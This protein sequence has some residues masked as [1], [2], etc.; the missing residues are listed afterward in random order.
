LIVH[1]CVALDP[2]V[3]AFEPSGVDHSWLE[4]DLAFALLDVLCMLVCC[5]L[6]FVCD[7]A[8]VMAK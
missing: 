2:T 6:V 5:I 1:D 3:A 7:F 8:A 4:I